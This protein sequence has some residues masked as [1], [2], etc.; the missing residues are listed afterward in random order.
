[1]P[2]S[3]RVPVPGALGGL[4]TYP[5]PSAMDLVVVCGHA[6]YTA[7]DYSR[8]GE[9]SSW[10]LEDYQ[11]VKGRAETFVEHA[12]VGVMEAANNPKALLVFSG[13][14]TRKSAGSL[15]EGTSYWEVARANRWFGKADSVAPRA[16]TEDFAR[17]SLENVMFSITRFHE[18]TGKVPRKLTVVGYEFK[19]DRFV[20]L[21]RAA[22]RFPRDRFVYVGTGA[23]G[24][25]ER[26]AASEIEVRAQFKA[27]PY[28]CSGELG[29]KR[30]ER[31]PF[32]V[33][34]P[35]SRTNPEL[36]PLLAHCGP[37]LF[38]GKLPWPK[39]T[40]RVGD[41]PSGG[42]HASKTGEGNGDAE[43]GEESA[44]AETSNQNHA[45]DDV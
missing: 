42:E 35:Y 40:E 29:R 13:G 37:E 7:G 32:N 4:E 12:K 5:Y 1:M 21:H 43:K 39:A 28:G 44:N 15:G 38:D 9:E 10:Y 16:F 19:R 33:G 26:S 36:A 11:R 17:D 31:D 6:V 30:R 27:D 34:Q 25:E 18:L 8:A 24:T 3:A 20:D 22:L 14:K 2:G 45:H 41:F 23:A